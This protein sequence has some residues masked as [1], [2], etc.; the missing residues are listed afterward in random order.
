[1]IELITREE[2]PFIVREFHYENLYFKTPYAFIHAQVIP[3]VAYLHLYMQRFGA[4]VLKEL[5]N[6]LE[7]FKALMKHKGIRW[8]CGTHEPEGADKWGK[9]LSLLGF[10]WFSDTVTPEGVPCRFTRMEI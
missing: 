4:S 8:V 10:T 2:G 9:F 5:R 1:M 6:D 7:C 3:G